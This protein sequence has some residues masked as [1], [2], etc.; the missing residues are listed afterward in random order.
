MAGMTATNCTALV[1]VKS[2][3]K[4]R[5]CST[6]SDIIQGLIILYLPDNKDANFDLLKLNAYVSMRACTKLEFCKAI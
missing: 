3:A 1:Y 5:A 4:I 2:I 6:L